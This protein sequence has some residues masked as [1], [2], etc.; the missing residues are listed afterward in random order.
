MFC[1]YW[2]QVGRRNLAH[3]LHLPATHPTVQRHL[4]VGVLP[5][6]PGL[7][8]DSFL[9]LDPHQWQFPHPSNPLITKWRVSRRRGAVRNALCTWGICESH[10]TMAARNAPPLP[11]GAPRPCPRP[12]VQ[13]PAA[14]RSQSSTSTLTRPRG[15]S[16]SWLPPRASRRSGL[17]RAAQARPARHPRPRAAAAC[18]RP[19][20]A[21]CWC[22]TRCGA[23]L[24]DRQRGWLLL[25]CQEL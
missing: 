7:S 14:P 19:A 2:Q 24:V 23:G 8:L 11:L 16:P 25:G 17:R 4:P 22:R 1:R 20:R 21:A 5:T 3:H 13:P 18:C 12:F 15:C 10:I 6:D 9:Q